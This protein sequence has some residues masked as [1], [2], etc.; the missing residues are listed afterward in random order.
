MGK[1][2]ERLLLGNIE[3]RVSDMKRY[4]ARVSCQIKTKVK[5]TLN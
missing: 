3:K 5:L 2:N 1:N 4:S